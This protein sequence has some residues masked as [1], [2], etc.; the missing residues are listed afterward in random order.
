MLKVHCT[1][2]CY[3]IFAVR[4]RLEGD[5]LRELAVLLETFDLLLEMIEK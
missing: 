2:N 5:S 4:V 3:V 1:A